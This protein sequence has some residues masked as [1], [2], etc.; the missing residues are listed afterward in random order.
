MYVRTYAEQS[1]GI[2]R[3]E[4][5]GQRLVRELTAADGACL[6]TD[7]ER[8]SI[9]N[10]ADLTAHVDGLCLDVEVGGLSR[11]HA[12]LAG[13]AQL[14]LQLHHVPRLLRQLLH[15]AKYL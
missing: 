5:R 15:L 14:F 3:A 1:Y 9:L 12:G 11:Y 8:E 7:E 10:C 6:T 13:S 4:L 2:A